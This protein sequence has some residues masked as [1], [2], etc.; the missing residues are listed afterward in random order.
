MPFSINKPKSSERVETEVVGNDGRI[1][2]NPGERIII[3]SNPGAVQ[4]GIEDLTHQIEISGTTP[5]N[6]SRAAI[7]LTMGKTPSG[8]NGV[9]CACLSQ[10][11]IVE[12]ITEEVQKDPGFPTKTVH[13]VR[14]LTPG[15]TTE[16]EPGRV[17]IRITTADQVIHLVDGSTNPDMRYKVTIKAKSAYTPYGDEVR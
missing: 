1:H 6:L 16:P 17:D 9:V 15:E 13:R 11:N 7:G 5:R 2:L 4:T 12:V 3:G 8:E 14:R 10:N